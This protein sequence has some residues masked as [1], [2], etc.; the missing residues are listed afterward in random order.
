MVA[1]LSDPDLPAYEFVNDAMFAINPP[2]PPA[3]KGVFERFRFADAAEWLANNFFDEQ[4]DSLHLL[5]IDRLPVQIIA[6]P[7]R[8]KD[9]LHDGCVSGLRLPSASGLSLCPLRD[10]ASRQAVG[11]HFSG[12]A[13]NTLSH[14]VPCSPPAI[15]SPPPG[16]GSV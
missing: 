8:R 7:L 16:H 9:Q 1:E 5:W 4:V 3:L 10:S 2:R 11:G 12:S 6:P 13:S 15:P 14:R